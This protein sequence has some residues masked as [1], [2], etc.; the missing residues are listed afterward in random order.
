M[1]IFY[2]FSQTSGRAEASRPDADCRTGDLEWPACWSESAAMLLTSRSCIMDVGVTRGCGGVSMA[3]TVLL[4]LQHVISHLWPGVPLCEIGSEGPNQQLI[5][6]GG[7]KAHVCPP[8]MEVVG[9]LERFGVKWPVSE[10][11]IRS[12]VLIFLECFFH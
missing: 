8:P 6:W 11:V 12:D 5:K 3:R 7:L 2:N 1:G 10:E 9:V 4:I